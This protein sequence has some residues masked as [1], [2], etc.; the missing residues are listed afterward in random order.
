MVYLMLANGFEEVEALTP[1]DVLRRAEITVQT[2]GIGGKTIQSARGIIV[3]ADVLPEETD[4]AQAEMIILP[5]G[6]I[7]TNNLFA[8][9]FV[10]QAVRT[11]QKHNIYIGAICAAPS[12]ILGSMGVLDGKRATCYPGMQDGM[13]GAQVQNVAVCVDG[14]IIT[15]RAAGAAFDFAF[16]LC[17]EI[18]GAAVAQAVREAMHYVSR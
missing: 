7:G 16:A 1:L 12:V 15:A 10:K 14:K 5:G 9:D 13:H 2:V 8:S 6:G 3:Q 11:C 4:I 18:K 17:Q